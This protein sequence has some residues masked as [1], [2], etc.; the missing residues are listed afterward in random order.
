M[1]DP[2]SHTSPSERDDDREDASRDSYPPE[3]NEPVSAVDLDVIE[4]WARGSTIVAARARIPD[5]V[6]EVR[7]LRALRDAA[8]LACAS[9]SDS[10]RAEFMRLLG[11]EKTL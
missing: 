1:T 7:R 6:R 4:Q 3:T 9:G 8:V 10:D 5:L 11:E 2:T